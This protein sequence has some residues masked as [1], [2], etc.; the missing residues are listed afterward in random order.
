MSEISKEAIR[1]FT[2]DNY[3]IK[4]LDLQYN[5][6]FSPTVATVSLPVACALGAAAVVISN[7][8]V[9]RRNIFGWLK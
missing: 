6:L 4:N 9:S 1:L 3:F 8:N 7:P 2:N 5:V